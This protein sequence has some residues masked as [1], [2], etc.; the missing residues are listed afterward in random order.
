MPSCLH[1]L[2]FSFDR[3][4]LNFG[5]HF[6]PSWDV[7]G[8]SWVCFGAS[9][10]RPGA[11]WRQSSYKSGWESCF[12]SIFGS[13]L[14][15]FFF[16][17]DVQHQPLHFINTIPY[18]QTEPLSITSQHQILLLLREHT[19]MQEYVTGT[20]C[21]LRLYEDSFNIASVRSVRIDK[22]KYNQWL[23]SH[24]FFEMLCPIVRCRLRRMWPCLPAF[25][26][27]RTIRDR[28]MQR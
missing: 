2:S 13:F 14:D 12:A 17:I 26:F 22:Q 10:G 9:W 24:S 3:F 1:M 7:L 8:A 23:Y 16:W 4:M 15:L 19:V 21:L 6:G 5:S 28:M 27:F 20:I 25:S 11:S 18:T